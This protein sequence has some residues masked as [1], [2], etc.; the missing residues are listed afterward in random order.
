V[1]FAPGGVGRPRRRRWSGGLL[2]PR[3]T[4]ICAGAAALLAGVAALLVGIA[5]GG[6]PATAATYTNGAWSFPSETALNPPAISVM[7]GAK[8]KTPSPPEYLFMAP[9]R[10]LESKENF[11]GRPGPEIVE[12]NGTLIWE[13]PLGRLV[14]VGSET[15]WEV[16]MDFHTAAYA[17][18]PVLVWWQGYITPNGFGTG[19]WEIDNEHYQTIASIRAPKGYETD[20]HA[21]EI[22]PNGMA[23]FL[24]SKTVQLNL[25]CC[26][27]PTNGSL[28]DQVV[29]EANIKTQ[30]IEWSWDPLQ[31]IPLHESYARVPGNAPWDPYHINSISLDGNGNVVVSARDTWAAYW[32]ARVGKS[33]GSVFAT[34][35]GKHSSFNL[36]KEVRF[37]WQHDVSEL[38]GQLVSVFADEATPPEAKQS[39]GVVIALDWAKHSASLAH[40]YFLPHPELTG[41]QGSVEVLHD[42]NVFVG[43]G[44]LPFFS[45]YSSSGK[46]LYLGTLHSADESYRTYRERWVGLPLAKPDITVVPG[47]ATGLVDVG[48]SWNGATDV[49]SWQFL[50]GSSPTTL[51]PLSTPVPTQGFESAIAAEVSKGAYYEVEA[52][53]KSGEVLSTSAPKEAPAGT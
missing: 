28:Y 34:L 1:S 48:A 19:T 5:V 50:Q 2:A 51:A 52:L 39:R 32:V 9:I 27:G 26:G 35:G 12:P 3:F 53:G 25:K 45:E 46:L 44:Q 7:A 47:A 38:P 6:S 31:H 24:A 10:N 30:H 43:W 36:G 11:V 29:F 42:G 23:Y 49:T 16:A 40:E 20:F 33:I 4:R 41:S 13:D 21:F 14:K 18:Q 15:H 8:N 17:G 37:S 22:T